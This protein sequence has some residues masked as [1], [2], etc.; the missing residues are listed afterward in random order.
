MARAVL[1]AHRQ[2]LLA[3][4]A[5]GEL[6]DIAVIGGGANGA[7]IALDAASRGLSVVLFER[8]DFGSGTSSRSSKLI[9]GGVRYVGLGHW[10]L[11]REA[12]TER[13]LLLDNAP[14][15]VQSKRFLIPA[16]SYFSGAKFRL[17]LKLY[18]WLGGATPT[19][20][21]NWLTP[22]EAC[23]LVPALRRQGLVGAVAYDDA[24]FDDSRLLISVLA[25]ARARDALTLNYCEVKA[26]TGSTAGRAD[27][28][29]IQDHLGGNNFTVRAKIIINAAGPGSD[30]VRR[31]NEPTAPAGI[32][33]SQGAHVVVP[34]RH[35]GG[36]Q[37][38]VLPHTSDGRIM[39][40]VPWHGQ[41]LLG[42]T[43]TV[44]ANGA[45][46]PEPLGHEIDAILEV[47][48]QFLEP[49]PRRADVLC[50]FAGIRPLAGKADG[51]STVKRSREHVLEIDGA[52]MLSVSGGKW[53]TYRL[54][55]EQC[56]DLAV[57][58]AGLRGSASQT[59]TIALTPPATAG[60]DAFS[61][62]GF[63]ANE[64]RALVRER[65]D[66]AAP[67]HPDLPWC[68]AHFVWAARAEQATSVS[69]TLAY[70]SRAMFV[71]PQAASDITPLVAALMAQELGHG[72][73]WIEQQIEHARAA[74]Q[75]FSLTPLIIGGE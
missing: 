17:G 2:A 1:T 66:L 11:V 71:N 7:G 75:R 47:A 29:A 67:L 34:S 18:D 12:L 45:L 6:F 53:T 54:I 64:L 41:V 28:L 62:W 9:H 49:A 65:P 44:V 32:S 70:R 63:A 58:A 50:S 15:I 23:A 40:A 43:D 61:A 27:T 24:V 4:L 37:A 73:D 48:G 72:E 38:L 59:A 69:D 74:A 21:S 5:G 68:G 52:G 13:S 42:T 8:A 14:G 10:K 60:T 16:Y 25:A 26:I 56:V 55:A 36:Q 35:L 19:S 20:K 30:V 22:D 31:L 33:A 46:P 57:T 3:R 39:F 51:A